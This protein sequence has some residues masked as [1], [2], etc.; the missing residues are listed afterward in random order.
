M[1]LAYAILSILLMLTAAAVRATGQKE[2]KPKHKEKIDVSYDKFK[3]VTIVSLEAMTISYGVYMGAMATGPGNHSPVAAVSVLIIF[4]FYNERFQCMDG[5]KV[6][7]LIDG[8]RL[9]L[10]IAENLDRKIG[11]GS[12]PAIE[13]IGV[14]VTPELFKTIASASSIEFQAGTDEGSLKSQHIAALRDFAARLATPQ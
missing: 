8:K 7:M 10:G 11:Y 9:R 12:Y 1:K 2:E 3:D 5:C 6:I 14:L 4:K 13:T